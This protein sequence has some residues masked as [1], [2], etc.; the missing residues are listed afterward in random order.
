MCA[1][2]FSSG[3][4]RLVGDRHDKQYSH[5]SCSEI[6]GLIVGDVDD[7]INR[8]DIIVDHRASGLQ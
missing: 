6:A 8:R 4:I 2:W 5:A 3:E 7:L 1:I